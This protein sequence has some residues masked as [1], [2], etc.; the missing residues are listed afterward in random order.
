MNDETAYDDW[1]RSTSVATETVDLSQ[2]SNITVR[3]YLDDVRKCPVGWTLARSVAEAIDV[4]KQ[5]TVV[6]ASLDHDLG[7]CDECLLREEVAALAANGAFL[8]PHIP[9]GMEFVRWMKRTGVWPQNKPTVHSANGGEAPRMREQIDAHWRPMNTDEPIG[10]SHA[11]SD[12]R[13]EEL[14]KDETVK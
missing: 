6:E 9:N 7:A 14:T 10:V 11:M 12:Q 4:M 3:L 2:R 13:L 1:L 8:C 5:W